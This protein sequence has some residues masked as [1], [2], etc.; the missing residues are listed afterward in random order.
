VIDFKRITHL[1]FDCYGTIIDWETGILVALR[2]MLARHLT[3]TGDAELLRLYARL[4]AQYESGPYLPY[5]DVLRRV[6]AGIAE[7]LGFEPDEDDLAE[8][9][10]SL[11]GW[12]PFPDSVDALQRLA[13]RFKL[14]ILSNVDDALFAETAT[15]LPGIRF[16]DVITAEQIGSYKPARRNFEF[17]IDV[18]GV[19]A[20]RLLHVAQSLYHD[21][22]PAKALGLATV[23][24]NRASIVPGTGLSLPANVTPDLEVPDLT[25]LAGAVGL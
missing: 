23:W 25:S 5:R 20:D 16:H 19:K 2:R 9:P 6:A 3:E 8:L 22:V 13:R 24:V 4:E 12:P 21:H 1:S 10:A 11:G 15:A 18:L 7:E 17:A 14:V